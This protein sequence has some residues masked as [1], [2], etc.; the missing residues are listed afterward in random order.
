M[1]LDRRQRKKNSTS[2]ALLNAATRIFAER[3]IYQATID[4]ITANADLGKGTFYKHFSSRE[5]LLAMVVHQGFDMLINDLNQEIPLAAPIFQTLLQR[6]AQF[7]ATHPG[8]LLIFHQTRGWLTMVNPDSSPIKEEFSRYIK[9]IA[10]ILQLAGPWASF[11]IEALQAQARFIAG[12][13]AGVLSFELTMGSGFDASETIEKSCSAFSKGLYPSQANAVPFHEQQRDSAATSLLVTGSIKAAARPVENFNWSAEQFIAEADEW[14]PLLRQDTGLETIRQAVLTRVNQLHFNTYA[15]HDHRHALDLVVVRDCAQAWQGLLHPRSEQLGGCSVLNALMETA[16]GNSHPELSP[17]F[18]AEVCHLVRGIEGGSRFHEDKFLSMT[19]GLSGR[20]AAIARSAELDILGRMMADWMRRYANGMTEETIF[21]RVERRSAILEELEGNEEDWFDWRWHIR[22]IARSAAT[23]GRIAFLSDEEAECI[24]RANARNIPFG[25]TPYYAS[26]FDNDP[27]KGRDRAIRFQVIPPRSYI[28]AFAA[29]NQTEG[30]CDFMLETD[31]SPIQLITRRYAAIAIFK[32]YNSC[33]QICV[34]CQRNWE[35]NGPL[36]PHSLAPGNQIEAAIA[37]LA[38][39]PAI[40]EV[41]VTGGDPLVLSD[42]RLKSILDGLAAIPHVERIRIGTR[43]LGTLPMRFT[44]ALCKLL[45]SYCIPGR[46]EL[47]VVTHIEHPY[48]VTPELAKA[49]NRLRRHGIA[50]YNQL[51]YTFYTSRRFE[52]A[53]LRRLLRRCG[54]DPYYTFYPKGKVE[55]AEYRVPI[56]RLLQEQKEEA[57]LLPGMARTDEAVFNVPGLG[58][59]S[60]N[61]SQHRDLIAIRPNGARVYEFHPWE[62]KIVPQ[63]T[64]VGEDVP[65]LDYLERLAK[66]GED[67]NEYESIWYYY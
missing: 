26:L 59:N 43:T 30:V 31:T 14:L 27:G 63:E 32:P 4:E 21:Q 33:P 61:S 25:V 51:V 40:H 64:Y 9:V 6:H 62:K 37:W 44:P 24:N 17:S 35:I 65:I 13:I 3:G 42:S 38:D 46:R 5:E 29:T 22:H 56:A 67:P 11:S 52:S 53:L 15:T 45:Q 58:K 23:L 57:R 39:H 7:Y 36:E 12:A 20:E 49:A 50:V 16:R 66:A 47:C 60:L 34:Y 1:P 28:D 19:E 2:H 54:I 18:W 55:L 10:N 41:L 8:Y 48:E